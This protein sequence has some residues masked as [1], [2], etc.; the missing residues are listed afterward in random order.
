LLSDRF[1]AS[2][3]RIVGL[4]LSRGMLRRARAKLRLYGD[5]VVLIWQDA[6][7]L[8]FADG[9]FDAVTCLEALEFMPRPL[10]VLK[11]MI[12]VLAPGGLL[13]V[14]NRVGREARLL[15]GRTLGRPLFQQALAAQPLH[16]VEIRPW[17]TNYDLAMAR[18]AGERPARPAQG[19]PTWLLRCPAC[20]AQLSRGTAGLSCARCAA[21]YPIREGIVH[22][23]S[24]S[25]SRGIEVRG[26]GRS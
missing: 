24:A 19:D 18:K 15:P 1:G 10:E 3:V 6:G 7:R 5:Q 14:T 9:T 2:G 21:S 22:L 12:R 17:Q 11:E 13:L 25:I 20:G 26:W 4:D 23:A 8:P 16:D